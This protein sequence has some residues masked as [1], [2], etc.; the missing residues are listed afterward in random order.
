MPICFIRAWSLR[1]IWAVCVAVVPTLYVTGV[2][3]QTLAVNS[4]TGSSWGS[5]G[6]VA[7]LGFVAMT[8]LFAVF[9][10]LQ[11]Q[12]LPAVSPAAARGANV[13]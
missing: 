3:L 6:P 4:H 11:K 12:A 10:L 1:E 8:V 5:G 7:G 2:T 13:L 9:R